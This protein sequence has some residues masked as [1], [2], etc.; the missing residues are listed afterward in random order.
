MR[1]YDRRRNVD[2]TRRQKESEFLTHAKRATSKLT[3]SVA[4]LR[5]QLTG[6]IATE[7]AV[8]LVSRLIDEATQETNQ[9][10]KA[11]KRND[12]SN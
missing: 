11:A 7:K 8:D 9:A 6:E 12:N 10:L 1:T 5:A 3:R 4:I 2:H